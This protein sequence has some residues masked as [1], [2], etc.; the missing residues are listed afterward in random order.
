MR[1]SS[2]FLC[3]SMPSD[4]IFKKSRWYGELSLTCLIGDQLKSIC[5][6]AGVGSPY[7]AKFVQSLHIARRTRAALSLTFSGNFLN[8]NDVIEFFFTIFLNASNKWISRLTR[9]KSK[10]H[11]HGFHRLISSF[12]LHLIQHM[13]QA[14]FYR[15]WSPHHNRV[16][17]STLDNCHEMTNEGISLSTIKFVSNILVLATCVNLCQ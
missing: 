9:I 11:L 12:H 10:Y 4:E 15:C 1:S 7:L 13:P 14:F 5:W 6:S 17:R 2:G 3:I 8:L 16:Y